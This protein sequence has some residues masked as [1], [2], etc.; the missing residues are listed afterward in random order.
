MSAGVYHQPAVSAQQQQV[1]VQARLAASQRQVP[2]PQ[3][4]ERPVQ[5]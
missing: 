5:P 2:E 3:A 4:Q 1:L